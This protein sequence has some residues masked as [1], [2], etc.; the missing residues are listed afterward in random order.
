MHATTTVSTSGPRQA[1][2]R[3]S[4]GATRINDGIVAA[5]ERRVLAALA[6]RMPRA[7][8]SDHLTALALAAMIGTGVSYGTLGA[9]PA[10]LAIASLLLAVNWFGDSLDGTLA[11]ARH[12]ERPRYGYYVDHVA[13][14]VGVAAVVAG[15]AAGGLMRPPIA[16]SL[17]LAYYL[18]SIE[19]YLAAHTVGRF[20]MS[21]FGFGPTELR[22]LLVAGN[23]TLAMRP[24]ASVGALGL[25]DVGGVAGAAG[26][27]VAF[28]CAVV[29]NTAHLWREEPLPPL[30]GRAPRERPGSHAS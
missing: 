18:L 3:V 20:Q 16:A 14:V 6:A 4:G 5:V 1:T 27:I 15:L 2:G 11:R 26:L 23:L 7:V 30:P 21:F 24:G 12:Q 22:L 10:G 9:T 8:T 17:L 13:D 19:V 28:A 25:F 29:R